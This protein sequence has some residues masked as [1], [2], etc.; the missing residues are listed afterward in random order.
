MGFS[1]VSNPAEIAVL[2]VAVKQTIYYNTDFKIV[3]HKY[4]V[5]NSVA[6]FYLHITVKWI[7]CRGN[8]AASQAE[9]LDLEGVHVILWLFPL[10]KL[11]L[12]I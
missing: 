5:Y 7:T 10:Q 12:N 1:E 3:F 6:Y 11:T 2:N 9:T 8:F 4:Y